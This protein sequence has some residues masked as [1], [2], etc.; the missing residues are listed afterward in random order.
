MSLIDA[1]RNRA[2]GEDADEVGA[3]TISGDA[4]AGAVNPSA[5]VS[6]GVAGGCA[7]EY[8][9]LLLVV[10]SPTAAVGEE[11]VVMIRMEQ[12]SA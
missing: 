3:R 12:L 6:R 4:G 5:P 2:V 8:E 11:G 9:A 1:L 7:V 10:L